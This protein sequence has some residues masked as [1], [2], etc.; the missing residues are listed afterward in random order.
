MKGPSNRYGNTNGAKHRGV[1]T[2]FI[3]YAWAKYFNKYTLKKH[4]NDHGKSMGFSNVYDYTQHAIKFANTVDRKNN[5][6]FIDKNGST[7]KYSKKTNEFAIIKKDG[8]VVTY[9]I[10]ETKYKYY[11][12]QKKENML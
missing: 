12:K 1:I 7:Y 10:P 3:G 6:S 11:L 9:F 8:T 4:Y 5:V 2:R